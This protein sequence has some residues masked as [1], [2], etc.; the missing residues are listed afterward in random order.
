MTELN[1]QVR[2]HDDEDARLQPENIATLRELTLDE[3][4]AVAGG[5]WVQPYPWINNY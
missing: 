2:Q 5:L 1:Y 3:Q 4:L